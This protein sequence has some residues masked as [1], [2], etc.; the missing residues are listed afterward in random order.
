[1]TF[2]DKFQKKIPLNPNNPLVFGFF[3]KKIVNTVFLFGTTKTMYSLIKKAVFVRDHEIHRIHIV[4]KTRREIIHRIHTYSLENKT[5][6]IK[7]VI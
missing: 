5:R 4:W 6:N 1:M 7:L 2:K 3:P